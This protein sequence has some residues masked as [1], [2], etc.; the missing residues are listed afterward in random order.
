[1]SLHAEKELSDERMARRQAIGS[2]YSIR[3]DNSVSGDL[4]KLKGRLAA[5]KAELSAIRADVVIATSPIRRSPPDQPRVIAVP[6]KPKA[7]PP[8]VHR[9]VASTQ[10]QS[11]PTHPRAPPAKN[12]APG[13]G[14]PLATRRPTTV[15]R[16]PAAGVT[17]QQPMTKTESMH[18]DPRPGRQKTAAGG[19]KLLTKPAAPAAATRSVRPAP[20]QK[21]PPTITYKQPH[22]PSQRRAAPAQTS[23]ARQTAAPRV[24]RGAAVPDAVTARKR[25]V[26][27]R[28]QKTAAVAP[29][30]VSAPRLQ[31]AAAQ[32]FPVDVDTEYTMKKF[33]AQR[34]SEFSVSTTTMPQKPSL[35]HVE[36]VVSEVA[37]DVS[38]VVDT[39]KL[40]PP[41]PQRHVSAVN[42]G[43]Y[44]NTWVELPVNTDQLQ[45]FRA[46]S[47]VKFDDFPQAPTTTPQQLDD[48]FKAGAADEEKQP[49]HIGKTSTSDVDRTSIVETQHAS[50]HDD[51]L[52]AETSAAKH[53][54]VKTATSIANKPADGNV[55]TEKKADRVLV[56]TSVKTKNQK[57]PPESTY[58]KAHAMQSNEF[59]MEV[60]KKARSREGFEHKPAADKL[61]VEKGEDRQAVHHDVHVEEKDNK[62]EHKA[63]EAQATKLKQTG[64]KVSSVSMYD[65]HQTL[66]DDDVYDVDVLPVSVDIPTSYFSDND[67]ELA[68]LSATSNLSYRD[69]VN[70]VFSS[71]TGDMEATEPAGIQELVAGKHAAK[72]DNTRTEVVKVIATEREA[73]IIVELGNEKREGEDAG[74]ND[75]KDGMVKGRHSSSARSSMSKDEES[76]RAGDSDDASL[77]FDGDDDDDDEAIYWSGPDNEEEDELMQLMQPNSVEEDSAKVDRSNKTGDLSHND[78]KCVLSSHKD[79]EQKPGDQVASRKVNKESVEEAVAENN[80]VSIAD[81]QITKETFEK[82]RSNKGL[83]EDTEREHEN[84]CLAG[85]LVPVSGVPNYLEEEYGLPS[86]TPL[87]AEE[88]D[89]ALRGEGPP[90]HH[91]EETVGLYSLGEDGLPDFGAINAQRPEETEMAEEDA[92]RKL[93]GA[94]KP[95]RMDDEVSILPEAAESEEWNDALYALS[96]RASRDL[97][98]RETLEKPEMMFDVVANLQGTDEKTVIQA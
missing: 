82:I 79:K 27:K 85:N 24:S 94:Q 40:H 45:Q 69:L 49:V 72:D 76:L 44:Q 38:E 54:T 18:V 84:D 57:V 60:E 5:A 2:K 75:E 29:A 30:A 39:A 46:D 67:P 21:K 86:I 34:D 10:R 50:K 42:K 58:G 88:Q 48:Q 81:E 65:D 90:I 87:D 26:R 16:R 59:L 96:N 9:P 98:E 13:L 7:M 28:P 15:T 17:K 14:V 8:T 51:N 74:Q 71:P 31:E 23:A 56:D 11:Q 35:S 36:R 33:M 53:D 62:T 55:K 25:E 19:I 22:P 97:R 12:A 68:A 47:E 93:I 70:P 73:E 3:V 83:L 1:V 43:A 63:E 20:P 6:P 95:A 4:Q 91:D 66:P 37:H 78:D 89:K 52:H 92:T 32:I 80:T 64:G 61:N 77:H 41:P